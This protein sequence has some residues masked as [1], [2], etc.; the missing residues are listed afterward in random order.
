MFAFL[1][2]S[3]SAQNA[4]GMVDSVAGHGWQCGPLGSQE[5]FKDIFY[6]GGE[7]RVHVVV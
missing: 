7:G 6:G 2:K 5:G 3:Y 1:E 4:R